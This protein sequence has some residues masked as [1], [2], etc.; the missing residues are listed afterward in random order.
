VP[1]CSRARRSRG[2]GIRG[3]TGGLLLRS[4]PGECGVPVGLG[5]VHLR[6]GG[7]LH[8]GDLGGGLLLVG[9]RAGGLLEALDQR[10]SPDTWARTCSSTCP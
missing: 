9:D 2:L 1:W 7:A 3:V 5:L 6:A 10:G 8:R 4:G